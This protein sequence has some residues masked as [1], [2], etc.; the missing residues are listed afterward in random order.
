MFKKFEELAK[1]QMISVYGGNL[2]YKDII[3][4]DY[5]DNHEKINCNFAKGNKAFPVKLQ[6]TDL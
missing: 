2:V 5:T 6:S 3:V 1:K 4:D